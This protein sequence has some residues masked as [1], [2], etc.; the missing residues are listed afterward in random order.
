MKR[1]FIVHGWEGSPEK[2]WLPWA[3]R[4][5]GSMGYEVHVPAMPDTNYPKIEPWVSHLASIIGRP[6]PSDVLIGHSIG[7]QAILRYLQNLTTEEE[8][9]DKVIF[10]AGWVD[11]EPIATPDEESKEIARP[12][13]TSPIDFE[14]ARK[15]VRSSVAIFGDSDPWVDYRKNSR[16]FK[17]KL[18]A[19]IVVEK[20]EGHFDDEAGVKELPILL[21]LI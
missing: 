6:R 17:E 4:K 20:G 3:E 9:I 8:K 16:I 5:L 21:N 7:C 10:V 13:L 2:D 15:K 14:T 1:V 19:K 12:W 11:L 18:G